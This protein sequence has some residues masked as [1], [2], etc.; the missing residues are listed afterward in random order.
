MRAPTMPMPCWLAPM[1]SIYRYIGVTHLMLDMAPAPIIPTF[2]RRSL[3]SRTEEP[4]SFAGF[5]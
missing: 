3:S 5:H 2:I 4:Y 1:P